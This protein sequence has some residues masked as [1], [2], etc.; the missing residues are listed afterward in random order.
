[1]TARYHPVSTILPTVFGPFRNARE[2]RL[3]A[4]I[5]ALWTRRAPRSA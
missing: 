3:T 1:M 2:Q 5:V 4:K